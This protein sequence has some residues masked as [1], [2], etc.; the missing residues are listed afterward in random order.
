M[1][2]KACQVVFNVLKDHV[3]GRLF[4]AFSGLLGEVEFYL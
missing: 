4:D 2:Q 1:I 3:H